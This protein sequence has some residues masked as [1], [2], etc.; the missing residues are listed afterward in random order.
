MIVKNESEIIVKLLKSVCSFIDY[1]VIVDTGSE[2]NTIQIISE[3]F[4][5]NEI[6]GKI[7]RTQF[8][9]FEKRGEHFN[10]IFNKLLKEAA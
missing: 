2:D 3:F 5:E 1:F 10:S 7:W 6:P 8:E 4:D 9:N